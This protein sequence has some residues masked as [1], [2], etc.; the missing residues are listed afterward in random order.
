MNDQ[1]ILTGVGNPLNPYNDE[2]LS[3]EDEK[4][5]D[6][7]G[8]LVTQGLLWSKAATGHY[9]W[10]ALWSGTEL[11][12]LVPGG[13]GQSDIDL[14]N[15]YSGDWSLSIGISVGKPRF[16][17]PTVG[18][19]FELPMDLGEDTIKRQYIAEWLCETI[20]EALQDRGLPMDTKQMGDLAIL[21]AD[22]S[23]R[24]IGAVL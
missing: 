8:R 12:Q 22:A 17:K 11:T 5:I 16:N 4:R 18:A 19:A 3:S 1:S 13:K 21:V 23:N 20:A 14:S 10:V 24:A 2:L 15:V 7:K 6:D 9:I